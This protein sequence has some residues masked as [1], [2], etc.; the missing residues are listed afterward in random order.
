MY[1]RP[2]IYLYA[3]LQCKIIYASIRIYSLYNVRMYIYIYVYTFHK[4]SDIK[5]VYTI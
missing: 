4:H 1:V 2:S 5:H 3:L